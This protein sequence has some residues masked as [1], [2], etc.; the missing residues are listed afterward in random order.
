[1]KVLMLLNEEF[2][3]DSRVE[4]EAISLIEQGHIVTVACYS[5]NNAPEFEIYK[6]IEIRRINL[7]KI[8]YKLSAACLILPFYFAKWTRFTEAI[9]KGFR[10]DIIHVHDLPLSKVGYKLKVKYQCK[11]ICDQHEFYSD[12]IVHTA[13]MNT[14]LGKIVS[15]LSNWKKYEEYY[16]KKADLVLTVSEN[17]RQ[18]YINTYNLDRNEILCIPNTPTEKIYNAKNK[19]DHI[20]DRYRDNFMIFYAGGIDVLRGINTAIRALKLLQ[21]EIP[22]VKLVLA[23]KIIKP[24]DPFKVAADNNVNAMFDFAGWIDEEDLPSYI[25][26][27]KVC[28]FT[29]PANRVEINN[30]IATKIFQYA[31]MDRPII[32]SSAQIMKDFVET[33]NLGIA[34]DDGDHVGF[35][36]AILKIEK[37]EFKF[38]KLDLIKKK[39][40]TWECTV[41]PMINAYDKLKA[42]NKL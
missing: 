33:N 42:C 17:L 3:P 29:P 38:E 27:S 35:A 16:L 40:I 18:N 4:K 2:P 34:I 36:Y 21:P 20:I 11:L 14:F 28:F 22:N 15:S 10:P 26:A 41:Q 5:L 32:T 6:G 37:G 1:M 30:T 24:Y 8:S 23:G 19:K 12:W 25:A 39:E 7:N 9:A 31:I 13:H